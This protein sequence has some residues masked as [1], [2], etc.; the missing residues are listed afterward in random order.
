MVYCVCVVSLT[1]TPLRRILFRDVTNT[2]VSLLQLPLLEFPETYASIPGKRLMH[3]V[4]KHSNKTTKKLI[5]NI[6]CKYTVA[7]NRPQN[8]ENFA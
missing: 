1:V 5:L 3:L 6:N 4:R 7:Y 2:D 8:F